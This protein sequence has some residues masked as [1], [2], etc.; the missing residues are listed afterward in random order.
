MCWWMLFKFLALTKGFPNN[1][2]R[3]KSSCWSLGS[4]CLNWQRNISLHDK[5][6]RRLKDKFTKKL[7][8]CHHLFTPMAMESWAKFCIPHFTA[9]LSYSILLNNI[10]TDTV[11]IDWYENLCLCQCSVYIRI[12]TNMQISEFLLLCIKEPPK[13]SVSL[14]FFVLI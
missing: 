12:L 14:P 8:C 9:I 11:G 3:E 6:I 4:M 10:F 2:P 7:K 13:P 5:K 1:Q